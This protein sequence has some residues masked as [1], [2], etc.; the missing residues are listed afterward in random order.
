[1]QETHPDLLV[2]WVFLIGKCES[3]EKKPSA[4]PP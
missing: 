4:V 3:L 1:M 2:L